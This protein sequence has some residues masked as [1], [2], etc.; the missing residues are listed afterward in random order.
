MKRNWRAGN[1][2]S[3][4]ENGEA[5]YPR[6]FECIAQARHEVI[7]ETFILF[8]D[9]VGLE[10]RR[11]LIEAAGRGVKVALTIDGWGSPDLSR[12]FID[13]LTQAGVAL[14]IFDPA[15]RLWRRLSLFRRLHRKIVVIDGERA[16][17]GG[18]NFSADHLGDFGPEAKQDYAVELLGPIVEDIHRFALRAIRPAR[19]FGGAWPWRAAQ[20]QPEPPLQGRPL[21]REDA[22][23]SAGDALPAPG[24]PTAA[25]AS[26]SPAGRGMAQGQ[27]AEQAGPAGPAHQAYQAHEVHEVHQAPPAHQVGGVTLADAASPPRPPG[28]PRHWWQR[29]AAAPAPA[30][31]PHAGSAQALLVTRDNRRHLDDI[32]RQYRL[33]IRAA[34][35]EVIIANAYFFPG[36]RLLRDL[37]A[38]AR[39]GVKVTLILQGQPDMAIVTFGAR[40]LYPYL[41]DAGVQIFEYCRRPLHGK[42]ALADD[43]WATVGSSNLDPLSLSLNLEANVVLLDRGFNQHLRERLQ[44]LMREH[45]R[46]I[47]PAD[48][49]KRGGLRLML[50]VIAFHLLR[51]FPRWAQLLPEHKPRVKPVRPAGVPAADDAAQPSG[52]AAA[53]ALDPAAEGAAPA[54]ASTPAPA[55]VASAF[56]P[57]DPARPAGR[58]GPLDQQAA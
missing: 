4:L 9:K 47:Q 17:I 18:I 56:I 11:H 25:S 28:A 2:V 45:C 27:A 10:L 55:A 29:R 57:S 42:V 19:F 41:L 30:A 21:S 7:I 43:E 12:S 54:P 8:E 26:V 48:A 16:F 49:P 24:D 33:A 58:A 37:R 34:K 32:E 20:A 36:L 46:E 6:V 52:T 40:M 15:P 35:R 3:L 31:L 50:S 38:A 51:R 13:G 1:R 44:A 39:R 22:A 53:A 14:H 23:R 5:Y